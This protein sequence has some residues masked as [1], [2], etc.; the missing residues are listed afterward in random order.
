VY[1][2]GGGK[3]HSA[4][5]GVIPRR[6]ATGAAGARGFAVRIE[7]RNAIATAAAGRRSETTAPTPA[8]VPRFGAIQPLA[9]NHAEAVGGHRTSAGKCGQEKVSSRWVAA[10]NAVAAT[11]RPLEIG[12][13]SAHGSAAAGKKRS[14]SR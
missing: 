2:G 5:S 4:T 12:V 1:V 3:R 9:R 13:R 7:T 6:D 11:K 10:E 8:T 14:G